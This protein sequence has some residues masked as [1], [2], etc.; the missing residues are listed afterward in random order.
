MRKNVFKIWAFLAFVCSS[1]VLFFFSMLLWFEK[2]CFYENKMGVLMLEWLFA[3][4]IFIMSVYF[5]ITLILEHYDIR[6][7]GRKKK[8]N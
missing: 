4:I 5:F 3:L 2:V 6:F 8:K 7:V 1:L